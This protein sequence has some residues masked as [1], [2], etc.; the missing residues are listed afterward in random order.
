MKRILISDKPLM[1]LTEKII[2][3]LYP[4]K[5]IF[6]GELLDI[7][8]ELEICPKCFDKIP[9][10]PE[11][12]Y[13]SLKKFDYDS[14]WDDLVCACEYKGIIKEA[15]MRYKFFDKP[16]YCRA[17]GHL[18]LLKLSGVLKK[19]DFD[20]IVSVPL[21][22]KKKA[23]RGYNQ[24]L[25]ISREIS[26]KTGIPEKSNL[27]CRV[28]NTKSQS[29]LTREGRYFNIRNAFLIKEK[30]EIKSKNIL[31]FDDILTTGYTLNECSRVLKEAGAEKVVAAVIASPITTV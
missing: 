26:R 14:N 31:I 13:R 1:D 7:D 2:R 8:T 12:N 17:F 11:E 28:K 5:C 18:M 27:L 20:M 24:S 25:L 19:Y 9:F 30:E 15:I 21:H 10:M 23:L 3:L 16:S 29:T 6:C 22:R 4:P